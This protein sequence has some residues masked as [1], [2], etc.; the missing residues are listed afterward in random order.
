M[1]LTQNQQDYIAAL[2]AVFTEFKQ[3]LVQ[4]LSAD[5]NSNTQLDTAR[6]RLSALNTAVQGLQQ[7]LGCS[8]TAEAQVVTLQPNG[9][10]GS[11]TGP[12]NSTEYLNRS[13]P[14]TDR[15][16]FLSVSSNIPRL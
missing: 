8:F 1:S 11:S 10:W 7:A 4:A 15:V 2:Q 5:N 9:T 12:G 3:S 13:N 14:N 16:H 6:D